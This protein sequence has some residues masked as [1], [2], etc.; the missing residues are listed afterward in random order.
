MALNG[1][2]IS[3]WQTGI[4][5][6]RVPCDFAIVKATEGTSYV[7]P[8]CVRAVEQARSFG[9]LWGVY[10]YINGKGATA[11]ADFFV[12]NC[13]NW[14]GE[15]VFCLDWESGGNA[16]WGN[17]AYLEQVVAQVVK[18]TGIPP[19]IYV[20]ASRYA[21]TKTVVDRHDCG[22]WVAQYAS[23][24]PTGYQST[25]W[26]EGRYSCAIRQ[27]SSAGRLNGWNGNLDLNKFYGDKTTWQ[28]YATGGKTAT[29]PAPSIPQITVDG[30]WG[31]ATTRRI[32]QVLNA[33]YV[34]GKISRQNPMWKSHCKGCT[35]GWEWKLGRGGS[36]TVSLI[37]QRIGATP[38]GLIGPKTINKLIEH[39]KPVSGATT[40]DGR[41]DAP[42]MTIKAMQQQ[43]NKNQF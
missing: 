32:Q 39:F 36:Q 4:D 23:M 18:R 42:S 19:I 43:L 24:S 31:E 9:K 17:E 29:P 22:L 7:N 26:N 16:A 20:Q 34:D 41:L 2:D 15:G 5:L 12:D 21:Q 27:Y 3:S 38:D 14:V 33:P 10:H 28:A 40:L 11:E 6:S 30:Y 13:R 8:D 37:Q 25:P 1:I 35:G